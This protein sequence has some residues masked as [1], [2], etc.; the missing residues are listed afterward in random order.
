MELSWDIASYILFVLC[1]YSAVCGIV[2]Q[3]VQF[4]PDVG[5]APDFS[6]SGRAAQVIGAFCFAAG[7][8]VLVHL[9]FGLIFLV[10]IT[11]VGSILKD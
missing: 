3:K 11:A 7:I 5:D 9:I 10:L 6:V 2:F 4:G 8:V 1:M